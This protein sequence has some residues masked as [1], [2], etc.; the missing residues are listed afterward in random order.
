MTTVTSKDGTKIAYTRE[1]NGPPLIFVDGAWCHRKFG[2]VPKLA[3]LLS[4]RF[5][6]VSYD[7]RGRGES[8]DAST[9]A[10]EREIEDIEALVNAVGGSASLLG[11]SSGA[12][13][14]MRAAAAGVPVDRLLMYE[15]PLCMADAPGP[16]QPER[17]EEIERLVAV[18]RRSD[19]A[20]VF[21]TMVGMPRLMIPVMKLM[22]GVWRPLTKVAHTVPY[23]FAV[24]GHASA[25]KPL[26]AELEAAAQNVRPPALLMDGGKSP[27]W[28]AHAQDRLAGLMPNATRRTLPGQ[29]HN[30]HAKAI[31]PV[32]AEF[33]S[34][35]RVLA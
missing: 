25:S 15:A 28:M 6:F 2:P 1:G 9:Y 35:Q 5:T 31:A 12:V 30:V 16:Q 26:P 3:P 24:I 20:S 14:A 33:C 18:E 29:T 8:G 4:D 34:T 7:R 27:A 23:D 21:M 22:P 13:L 32:V 17:M 11:T 10:V 19:A